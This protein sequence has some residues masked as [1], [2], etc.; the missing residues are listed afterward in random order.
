MGHA[1]ISRV[2]TCDCH[3]TSLGLS[4]KPCHPTVDVL[5]L[6]Y[7]GSWGGGAGRGYVWGLKFGIGGNQK[8]ALSTN[9]RRQASR[10]GIQVSQCRLFELEPQAEGPCPS[11][12]PESNS[13]G[14]FLVPRQLRASCGPGL[15]L[16][17]IC[18]RGASTCGKMQVPGSGLQLLP[19]PV[20]MWVHLA[21]GFCWVN[22]PAVSDS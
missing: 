4:V 11:R 18:R 17:P 3:I 19:V 7:L 5:K 10:T 21:T 20:T 15:G 13:R 16:R 12:E 2:V 6:K 1:R 8:P 9:M 22:H 14:S